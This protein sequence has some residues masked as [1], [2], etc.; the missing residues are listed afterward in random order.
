MINDGAKEFIELGPGKVLQGLIK[1]IDSSVSIK[2]VD[3]AEDVETI[4]Q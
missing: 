4:N 3:K 2:G 1:R